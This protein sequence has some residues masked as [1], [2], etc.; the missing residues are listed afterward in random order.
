MLVGPCGD[1]VPMAVKMYQ[2]QSANVAAVLG[3]P[4]GGQVPFGAVVH[5]VLAVAVLPLRWSELHVEKCS[6]LQYQ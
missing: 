5:E 6:A 4:V 2:L 1:R 3:D